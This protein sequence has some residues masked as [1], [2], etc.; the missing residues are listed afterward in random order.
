MDT[1]TAEGAAL[2]AMVV[3][4]EPGQVPDEQ[5]DTAEEE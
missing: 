3:I 5:A 2:D 1:A 4:E